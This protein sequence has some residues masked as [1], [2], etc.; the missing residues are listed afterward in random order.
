MTPTLPPDS[1]EAKAR[2]R[3]AK[4]EGSVFQRGNDGR[5]VAQITRT[6]DGKLRKE[7]AYFHTEPEAQHHLNTLLSARAEEI[8]PGKILKEEYLEPLGLTAYRLAKE[9]GVTVPS[10]YQL[11][12]GKRGLSTTMALKLAERFGTDP[13]FWMKLQARYDLEKARR[14]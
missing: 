7:M 13:M 14:K 6:Q 4:G 10:V 11:T 2:K 9:L 3:R 12:T 8:H 5:W 1:G